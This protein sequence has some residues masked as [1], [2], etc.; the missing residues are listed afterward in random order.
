[1]SNSKKL[2]P[3]NLSEGGHS[4][5]VE[6][7]YPLQWIKGIG[8]RRAEALAKAGIVSAEDLIEHF[9][10]RY[11]D[12]RTLIPIAELHEHLWQSVAVRGSVIEVKQHQYRRPH[13]TEIII[14][15]KS[16]DHLKLVYFAYADFVAKQYEVGDEVLAIGHVGFYRGDAQ[17]V[18]P[19]FVEKLLEGT[20]LSE[21]R[22]L[23]VYPMSETLR[24]VGI[25]QNQ[26]RKILAYILN[27]SEFLESVLENLP[28]SL[29]KVHSLVERPKALRELHFPTSPESLHL[30]RERMK[31]EEL[32]FLQLRYGVERLRRLSITH[33]GVS[34]DVTPLRK[35]LKQSENSTTISL[36]E[37]VYRSLP[38]ELTK[39]QKQVL[40]EV[41]ADMAKEKG[42]VPMHRLVQGDVGSGKT[43]VALLAMLIAVENGYQCA[44]MA[45]T[46][47]LAKQHFTTIATLLKGHPVEVSLLIGGQAKKLR[48]EILTDLRTGTTNIIIGTHALLEENVQFDKLGLVVADEQHK[49]GVAQRKALLNKYEKAP[50]DVLVMSA[51]PI[52]RTLAMTLY[53]DLDV[54]TIDEL[55]L[56][57]KQIVTRIVFPKDQ[58]S[59]FKEVRTVV[60]RGEQVYI[61]YPQLE[62]STAADV[63]TAV[64]AYE[65]FAKKI[66]PDLRVGLVHGK[67]GSDEKHD[68]MRRFRQHELDILVATIVIE[69]GIDVPNATMMIIANA[70]RFGLA[71]LHQLRGRVGRGGKQSQCILIPS[72]KLEPKE[73]TTIS[74]DD[75][76]A[77]ELAIEKLRVVERTTDGFEISKADLAMR[78]PGD[79]LGTQQSGTIKLTIANIVTDEALLSQAAADVK[80]VLAEDPQLRNPEHAQT[81]QEFLKMTHESSY[82]GVG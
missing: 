16:N 20:E 22:M 36:T 66:Y 82:L 74:S 12:A 56:G 62:K 30:A 19:E 69:V 73:D 45:P 72:A 79:F 52:P 2:A 37:R 51:T 53:Q 33:P 41:A 65:V 59:L 6:S 29:I 58:R 43:V 10:R 70:E 78:G 14:K 34:F 31:Y 76:A 7:E 38:F 11:I 49:F 4:S 42:H 24:T 9:P 55:P 48:T 46:E 40:S 13:R 1:V 50:P 54:S 63:K 8:P 68:V 60:S 61:V 28:P 39:A 27:S 67:L 5:V 26:L 75:L 17:I 15:D 44:L 77:R 3:P 64:A 47:V 18:H 57:R 25:N 21:G 23:P 81:R 80:G 71:Q 35:A 32:F